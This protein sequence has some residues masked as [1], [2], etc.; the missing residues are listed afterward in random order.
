M[1]MRILVAALVSALAGAALAQGR[2]SGS[3]GP[4]DALPVTR[5]SGAAPEQAQLPMRESAMSPP[6]GVLGAPGSAP[7]AYGGS[8]LGRR[9]PE[10]QIDQ[11]PRWTAGDRVR[12]LS[13]A[14]VRAAR[15][16]AAPD[17]EWGPSSAPPAAAAAPG[18][19]PAATPARLPKAKRPAR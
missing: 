4:S 15:A 10:L 11:G 1:A 19:S 9:D 12:S 8:R 16:Q 6:H 5:G 3:G 18:A 2:G 14:D 7:D 17:L 13:S